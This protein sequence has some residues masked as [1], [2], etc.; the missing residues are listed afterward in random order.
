MALEADFSYHAALRTAQRVSVPEA[1]LARMINDGHMLDIGREPG[2]NRRHLLFYSQ[3]D[4]N[5]FVVVQDY[6]R[7]KVV[8]VLPLDYHKNLA[9]D[10][11]DAQREQAQALAKGFFKPAAPEKRTYYTT[12][13][14]V[15]N[16][17]RPMCRRL[18][19]WQLPAGAV[20]DISLFRDAEY[21]AALS[22]ALEKHNLTNRVTGFTVRLGKMGAAQ[23]FELPDVM[24]ALA[25]H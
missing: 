13:L 3:P 9:W 8:T 6:L 23:L 2:F 12:A 10:V 19:G 17:G 11:S 20:P 14:Y 24:A 21:V 4:Q 1:E 5:H 22:E 7:G 18:F 15:G 16:N 25:T